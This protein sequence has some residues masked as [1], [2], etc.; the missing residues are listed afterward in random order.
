MRRERLAFVLLGA[1]QITVIAAITM[2]TVALPVVQ[3]DLRLDGSALTLI[4]SAYSLSFGGLLLLGGKAADFLGHRRVFRVGMAIFA[5]SSVLAGLVPNL[6]LLLATRF[7]QGVGAALAV[8]A[9]MALLG[10]VFAE[11]ARRDRAVAVWGVLAST[12]ATLGTVLSGVVVTWVSWRWLFAAP[13][14]IAVVAAWAAPRLMPPDAPSERGPVDVLGG[15]LVTAGLTVLLYGLNEPRPV[16]ILVGLA[17]L[18]AFIMVERRSPAPLLPLSFPFAPRR[19]AA[20]SAILVTSGGMGAVYFL[21]TLNFAQ[22]RGYSPL[23]TSVAFLA[24]AIAVL[25]AGPLAGRILS[26]AAARRVML[27]GLLTSAAGLL[28][29]S[30]MGP[31]AGFLLAGLLVFPIGA[32]LA[33]S[34]ATVAAL[35]GATERERGLAGGLANTAMELGPPLA[36]AAF[37][38]LASHSLGTAF[39]VAALAFVLTTGLAAIAAARTW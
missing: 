39:T 23:R 15:V 3:R 9:A 14:V 35:D 1:V 5:V 16:P 26:R 29:I 18:A 37:T 10:S 2:I 13:A 7:G 17:L 32:G 8:P 4:A 11:P 20:L 33:F 34:G 25:A 21:L 36:L 28:L 22:D 12:G 38:P 19:A 30:R 27:F 6:A 31:Y 24:P